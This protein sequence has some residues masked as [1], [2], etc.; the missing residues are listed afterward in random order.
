[1]TAAGCAAAGLFSPRLGA[2]EPAAPGSAGGIAILCDPEDPIAAAGPAQWAAGQL[3]QA[4]VA[5]GFMVRRCAWPDE[6]D[7][8]DLCIVVSGPGSATARDAGV[9]AEAHPE[10]LAI[11]T[12]QLGPRTVLVAN[13][14]GVR[15]LVYALTELAEAVADDPKTALHPAKIWTEKPANAVRSVMRSFTS[16]EEDKAWYHDRDFW[17]RYLSMLVAQRFNRF[18]LAFGLGYDAP[19]R[20]RDTYLYFAYPFLLSVPGYKV[21]ATNLPDAER[22]QNLEM[23]RFISDE[24]ARRG[25]EF[26]LGLWTHAYEWTNSPDANYVITGLTPQTQATYSRDALALLLKECPNISGVTFRVHGESGVPE[27][28]YDLWKVIFDGCSRSGQRQRIDMHAKGMTNEMI[29]VALA[30]GSEFTISPK[31][32]AEHLGLPYHQASIRPTEMPTRAK[33]AGAYAASEGARSFLR[34]GYGD[35]L[36]EDRTYGIVTRVWPGT[37]RLMLWGDPAFAGGYG[38]AMSFCG[39]QGGEIF[40]P[41]SFKGREGSGLPGGRGG[42]AD[43]S[44]RPVGGDFE[45][46]LLTYRY[47]GRALYNPAADPQGWRRE[48][49]REFGPAAAPAEVVLRHASR[50]LPL[51]TTAHLPSA[52]NN[53]FWPEIYTN[54]PIVAGGAHNPYTDTPSPRRFGTVSPL[55]PQLFSRIEDHVD[56]QLKGAVDGKYSPVEVAQWLEDLAHSTFEHLAE[57]EKASADLNAPAF[58]RLAIDMR[59]QGGL[60]RFFGQKLRAG[61]LFALYERTGDARARDEALR[62]YRSAR[63]AWAGVV[64]VTTGVYAADLS[65]GDAPFKRGHWSDRLPAIDQDIAAMAAHV[66][67]WSGPVPTGEAVAGWVRAATGH[68]QRPAATPAHVPPDR[69]RRG[70]AVSLALAFTQ[71]QAQASVTLHYRRVNQVEAWHSAAMQ[72]TDGTWGGE[73][74]AGYTDSAFPLQ[75]YFEPATAGGQAWI[76]PGLGSALSR[77]PYYVL[78][79]APA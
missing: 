39:S 44:L 54:M 66:T 26:Q 14:G 40:E 22:D 53:T 35:L 32:W 36:A 7:V 41:L 34:Y 57:T 33:G 72:L 13:G 38:R 10:A 45:K 58:R 56:A 37:Q 17:Q 6:A 69:F 15:G 12:G 79:Q 21:R 9:R 2:Q 18:N 59:V 68:P 43:A 25:L 60:G 46:Y 75:Y 51:V 48:F 55:D 16:A 74:P 23:L 42:Y 65:Y 50:I 52:S 67:V 77:Q 3:Q 1:M 78:R 11:G 61:V 73:I 27:G 19:N 5:R 24:A 4:L 76:H 28:S 47:W 30:S 71:D 62:L 63:E 29:A 64:A 20:L 31:F 8:G 49:R 70:E